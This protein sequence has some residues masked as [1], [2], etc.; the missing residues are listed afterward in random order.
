VLISRIRRCS[1]VASLYSTIACTAPP[2]RERFD[3]SARVVELDREE[4]E[5]ALARRPQHRLQRVGGH[6]WIGAEEHERDAV[7]V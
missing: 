5:R 4:R 3:R 2:D 1:G 7:W 6:Q